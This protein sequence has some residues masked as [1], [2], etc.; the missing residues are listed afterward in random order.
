M[1]ASRLPVRSA[2]PVWMKLTATAA[3]VHQ[4]EP[5]PDVRKV[6]FALFI[7]AL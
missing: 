3:C 1:S 4:A 7:L 6:Q 2:L 5:D